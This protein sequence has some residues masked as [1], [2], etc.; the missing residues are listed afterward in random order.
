ML[1]AMLERNLCQQVTFIIYRGDRVPKE[2]VLD[3]LY[4]GRCKYGQL[5]R[6]RQPFVHDKLIAASSYE[7]V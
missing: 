7:R 1:K 2:W 6:K 5:S 4:Q 3:Q